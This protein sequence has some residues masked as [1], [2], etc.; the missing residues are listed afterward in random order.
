M[1]RGLFALVLSF[2]FTSGGAQAG[3]IRMFSYDPADAETR[4]AAGPMTVEFK[5]GLLKPTV[6][7]VRSTEADATVDLAPAPESELGARGLAALAGPEAS[8]RD[9]YSV[10]AADEGTALIAAL[11]PG[12]TRGW[13][14][15]SRPRYGRDLGMDVFGA[16]STGAARLCRKLAFTFHGE[17]RLPNDKK[18]DNR[19]TSR[20]RGPRG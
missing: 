7:T 10:R 20:P 8:D 13:L 11:C 12:S 2:G 1:N 15:I 14:A 4:A 5:P 9:L 16:P 19:I 6:L 18:F 17:W 3:A